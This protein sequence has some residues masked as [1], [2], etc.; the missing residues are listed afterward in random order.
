MDG[1]GVTTGGR[2]ATFDSGHGCFADGFAVGHVQLAGQAARG[3]I[4]DR[5]Y[6]H[7][8]LCTLF[9]RRPRR[10]SEQRCDSELSKIALY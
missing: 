3:S 4:R 1:N 8:G 10:N 7:T 2:C 6:V 9:R 5:E